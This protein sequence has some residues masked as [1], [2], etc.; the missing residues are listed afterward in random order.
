MLMYHFGTFSKAIVNMKPK[1]LR[2]FFP[3]EESSAM[4]SFDTPMTVSM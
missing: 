2:N 1:F 4:Q 3:A